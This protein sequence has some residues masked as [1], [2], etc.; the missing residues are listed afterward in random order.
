VGARSEHPIPGS[1]LGAVTVLCA[2]DAVV[3][4]YAAALHSYAHSAG[5]IGTSR[6]RLASPQAI[7][8]TTGRALSRD[9]RGDPDPIRGR[10][11]AAE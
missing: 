7:L 8:A 5:S 9:M 11:A 3:F 6:V 4:R 1:H 2:A 10:H